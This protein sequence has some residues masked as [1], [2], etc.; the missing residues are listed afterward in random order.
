MPLPVEY[1]HSEP[2]SE[3]NLTPILIKRYIPHPM[4]LVFYVPVISH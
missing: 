2:D 4:N 3:A 1:Y